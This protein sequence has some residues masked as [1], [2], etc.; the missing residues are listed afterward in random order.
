MT[1]SLHR[2]KISKE[3][4]LAG[5]AKKW[6]MLF[7]PRVICTEGTGLNQCSTSCAPKLPGVSVATARWRVWSRGHFPEPE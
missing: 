4:R 1:P 3:T 7:K 2:D 6:E 5:L